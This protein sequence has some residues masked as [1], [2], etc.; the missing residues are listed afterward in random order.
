MVIWWDLSELDLTESRDGA[1][2]DA[3]AIFTTQMRSFER[4]LGTDYLNVLRGCTAAVSFD[5]ASVMI[6]KEDSVATR[7]LGVAPQA[8]CFHAVAHRLESAYAD[9]CSEVAFMLFVG[10]LL[11]VVYLLLNASMK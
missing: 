8:L 5:G 3:P 1:P 7:W 11:Q 10:E 6:G 4:R 9:A 2:P